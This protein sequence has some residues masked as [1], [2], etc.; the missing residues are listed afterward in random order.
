M[1]TTTGESILGATIFCWSPFSKSKEIE[2]AE[3]REVEETANFATRFF[4]D[5][6]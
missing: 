5:M 1:S 4:L 3:A 2:E 6:T